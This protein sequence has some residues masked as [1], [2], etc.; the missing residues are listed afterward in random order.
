VYEQIV[1][2]AIVENSFGIDNAPSDYVIRREASKGGLTAFAVALALRTLS[3]KLFIKQTIV[4]SPEN[5]DQRY[6]GYSLTEY[7]W[8]WLSNNQDE[9]VLQRPDDSPF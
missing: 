1:I 7:A 2:A 9:F 3:A 5:E 6:L 8:Q 4:V